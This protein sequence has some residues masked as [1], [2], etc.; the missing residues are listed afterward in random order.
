MPFFHFADLLNILSKLTPR[1]MANGIALFSGFLVS[2]C[3]NRPVVWGHPIAVGIE[4]TTA[5]NLGCPECPSGL[6]AFTR[7]T[8]SIKTAFFKETVDALYKDVLYL[9]FY[10]QG[11]PFLHKGLLEMVRYAASK[12]MYTAISTNAHFLDDD[13]ARKTVESG[14]DRLIVSIDGASQATYEK[15]RIGG[16]LSKVIEGATRIVQWKKALK[17]RTPFLVFQFLVVK[18]NE[19]ELD[20]VRHLSKQIGVD[21]I[22]FKSAQIQDVE[23][24]PNQ[25]IPDQDR[26]SRYRK[27][28]SGAMRTKNK[29]KNRC[30][31]MWQG[32]TI[33]WDGKVLPCCFDKD[34]LHQL[35]DLHTASMQE[36][37]KNKNY[38]KFRTELMQSR[39]NID[40]CANCSEG[41]KI[42]S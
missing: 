10:F 24:D 17:R 5:C 11:E 9:N 7:P 18:P 42:W 25:L 1:R 15:Y 4:P 34:A 41:L 14:L 23:N 20:K 22:W 33:T 8:G 2:R 16:D 36:I 35:G 31:K 32:N 12:K 6:K 38:A 28:K 26:Y 29:L 40:I 30:W 19:H 39:K 13:Q 21:A 37:W 27:D 3:M